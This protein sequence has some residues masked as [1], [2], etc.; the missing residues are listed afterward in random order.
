MSALWLVVRAV[1][2]L[3]GGFSPMDADEAVR[4]LSGSSITDNV[5]R[6]VNVWDHVAS[7]TYPLALLASYLLI[8]SLLVALLALPGDDPRHGLAVAVGVVVIVGPLVLVAMNYLLRGTYAPI[9]PRY[10]ASLVPLQCAIAA[11]FWR[12]RPS[13]VP[14]GILAL[15]L[16]V[17]AIVVALD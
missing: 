17:A 7:R 10:G 5:A 1:V 11:S 9:E 6:F 13:L 16:P 4:R 3:P 12:S 15:V 2:A 8:G 14:V